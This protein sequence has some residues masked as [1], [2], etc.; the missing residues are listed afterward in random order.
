MHE[1]NERIKGVRG[2]MDKHREELKDKIDT[3]EEKVDSHKID[4]DRKRSELI[5]R[6]D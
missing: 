2:E 1:L 6:V 5:T 3:L 4:Q